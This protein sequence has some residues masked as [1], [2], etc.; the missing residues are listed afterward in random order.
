MWQRAIL[1]LGGYT[2]QF[3]AT[4]LSY[5]PKSRSFTYS[6]SLSKGIADVSFLAIDKDPYVT[7]GESGAKI[8][9]GETWRRRR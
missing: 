3:E 2:E 8:R 6:G 7:G 5:S 4:V 9:L 1:L